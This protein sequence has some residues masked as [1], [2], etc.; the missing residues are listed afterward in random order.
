MPR[1]GQIKRGNVIKWRGQLWRVTETQQTF[2]GKR[3]AYFQMKLQSLDDG[4]VETE[5]FNT[6]QEVEKAFVESRRMQY[7]YQDGPN[8]VFMNPDTGEQI[9]IGEGIL[10]DALSYLAY[11]AEVEVQLHEGRPVSLDMPASVALEVTKTEP[12]ARGDTATAVTKPAETETGLVVKVPGHVKTGDRIQVDTRTG[13][14]L[15]RA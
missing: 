6:S 3:G 5:R 8:Y 2:T 13:A 4:H 9:L 15:G 12:A 10:R 11:N 7:L 14:F 1:A